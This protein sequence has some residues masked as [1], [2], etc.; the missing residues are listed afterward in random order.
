MTKKYVGTFYPTQYMQSFDDDLFLKMFRFRR[1]HFYKMLAAMK[2]DGSR[3]I[4]CGRKGA[5]IRNRAQYFPADICIMIV[6]RRMAFPCRFVDLVNI[7]GLPTN[8]ICDIYHSTVDFLYIKFARKLNRF[9]IWKEHF[10]A[11]AQAFQDFGAPYDSMAGIFDGHNITCCRPGGLGNLNSRLDQGQLFSGEKANH[12]IKYMVAQFPNGMSALSG[13]Y[14]GSSHDS[15]CLRESLWTEYLHEFFL[16]TGRRF[17]LFGDAGFVVS[18]YIQ[19]MVKGYGGYMFN[20]ARDYN[21]LMS[22]I[23]IYI[24]NSFAGIANEF[25]YFSYSN[26]LRLGGRRFHRGYEVANFFMNV[27]STFYGNQF[28]DAMRFRLL[29]SLEDFLRMAEE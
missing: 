1:E 12:S 11:F 25:S 29:I 26:G 27:R 5:G 3:S 20:E 24:E 21:N 15:R 6:L 16:T 23:R 4:L 7:F 2:L 17:L 10:P 14:K 18:E 22:R 13:P 28:T 19:A 8:R 9:E